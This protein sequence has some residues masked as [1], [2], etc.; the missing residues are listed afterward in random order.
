MS[1]SK[2]TIDEI[3]SK[4]NQDVEIVEQRNITSLT[5][6]EAY[7]IKKMAFISTRFGKTILATLY[8]KTVNETF[9]SFLPKRVVETL[10][11][12]TIESMNKIDNKYSLTYLGQSTRVFSGGNTK[13]ILNFGVV[14]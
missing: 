5:I 10:S 13:A 1:I 11:E 12:D 7:V 8:D 2:Q 4:L 6:G 14:E 9:Q 3:N